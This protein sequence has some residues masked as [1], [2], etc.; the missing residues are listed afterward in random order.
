MI[1]FKLRFY[2][3]VSYVILK[4]IFGYYPEFT[5]IP[6]RYYYISPSFLNYTFIIS[7]RKLFIL[8][9]P[10]LL[11]VFGTTPDTP[12][13]TC[14]LCLLLL[15][16]DTP[17]FF[18]STL[19]LFFFRSNPRHSLQSMRWLFLWKTLQHLR[20]WRLR[21]FLQTVDPKKPPIR[22]QS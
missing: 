5:F 17:L 11:P 12:K 3:Y 13:G 6:N 10:H 1:F 18:L 9:I 20:L 21:R 22:L 15:L 2:V 14:A 7:C 16:G 4:L 19:I 8:L